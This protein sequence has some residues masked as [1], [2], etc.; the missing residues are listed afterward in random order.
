MYNDATIMYIGKLPISG[1]R[2]RGSDGLNPE[3][4]HFGVVLK[5][6]RQRHSVK[7]CGWYLVNACAM[8]KVSVSLDPPLILSNGI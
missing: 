4:C 6:Q 7:M 1:P 8:V 2:V 5:L 3:N